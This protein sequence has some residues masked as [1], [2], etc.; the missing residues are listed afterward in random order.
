MVYQPVIT[1]Q[2]AMKEDTVR[3]ARTGIL[4]GQGWV[5]QYIVFVVVLIFVYMKSVALIDF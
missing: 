4:D 3:N 1:A 2:R 5:I